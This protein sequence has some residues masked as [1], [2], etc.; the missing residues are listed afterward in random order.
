MN[1]LKTNTRKAAYL[2]KSE[3]RGIGVIQ[4]NGVEGKSVND[5][6]LYVNLAFLKRGMGYRL[7]FHGAWFLFEELGFDTLRFQANPK[8]VEALRLWEVLGITDT[9]NATD[10]EI[11]G[12]LKKLDFVKRSRD[13]KIFMKTTAL[14][15]SI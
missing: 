8:N 4:L 1:S 12:A 9:G 10:F 7:G 15:E 2:V 3:D 5:V 6:G 11:R 13:F 14:H